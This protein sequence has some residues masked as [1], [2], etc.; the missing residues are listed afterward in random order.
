MIGYVTLGTNDLARAARFYDE[1]FAVGGEHRLIETPGFIS[2]GQ[3]W[4]QPMF[5]IAR[6]PD[7]AAATAGLGTLVALVQSSRHMVDRVHARAIELGAAD[8]GAPAARA[9]EGD[10]DFYA[11]YFRDPDGNRLC[12]FHVGGEP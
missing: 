11:G 5:S 3:N 6:P 1:L 12:V 10:Q 4:D 2:W 9:H 7:G 8:D